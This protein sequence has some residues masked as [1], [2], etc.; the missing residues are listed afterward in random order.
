MTTSSLKNNP[1]LALKRCGELAESIQ[2]MLEMQSHMLPL[3][4]IALLKKLTLK[5]KSEH[6]IEALNHASIEFAALSLNHQ[7][8]LT[9]LVKIEACAS[10]AI[11]MQPLS[12]PILFSQQRKDQIQPSE[13]P[14][15][16]FGLLHTHRLTR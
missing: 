12:R 6:C 4:D 9:E 15:S 2:Q 7:N 16:S 5:L 10:P 3:R 13:T 14:K 1:N 8:I 11:E